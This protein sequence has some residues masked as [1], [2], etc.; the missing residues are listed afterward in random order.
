MDHLGSISTVEGSHT[1][2]ELGEAGG[3][4]SERELGLGREASEQWR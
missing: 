4:I 2:I 1:V 3:H